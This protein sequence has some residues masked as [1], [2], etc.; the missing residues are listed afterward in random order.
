M[1]C[2]EPCYG[3]AI[4]REGLGLGGLGAGQWPTC[5]TVDLRLVVAVRVKSHLFLGRCSMPLPLVLHT[6]VRLGVYRSCCPFTEAFPSCC[7]GPSLRGF[8]TPRTRPVHRA[9]DEAVGDVA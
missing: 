9:C 6:S 3:A 5:G 4:A 8:A 2:A 1:G 7:V